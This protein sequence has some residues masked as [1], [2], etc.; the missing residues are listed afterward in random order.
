MKNLIETQKLALEE[1][2]KQNNEFSQKM[3]QL[4]FEYTKISQENS[5]L[6]FEIANLRGQLET[7][8]NIAFK[9]NN[10]SIDYETKLKNQMEIEGNFF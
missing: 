3:D 4:L 2:E 5:Q 10:S 7:Y 8:K 9:K 6:K 1:K